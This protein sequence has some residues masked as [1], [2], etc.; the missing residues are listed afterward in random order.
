MAELKDGTLVQGVST[1]AYGEPDPFDIPKLYV[2]QGGQRQPIEHSLALVENGIDP[3]SVE[4]VDDA[5]LE[6]IPLAAKPRL[7][8]GQ[9]ITLDL[10]SFLGAGHYMKT[11]GV[12]RK[13]DWGAR[14]DATTRTWTVTLL[15]GFR[16]A[17][18]ILFSDAEGFPVGMTPT[19]SF[20]VD[21]KWIG[22]SDR[23]DFWSFDL[24]QDQAGRTTAITIFHFWNP[25]SLQ[26]TIARLVAAA[27]P[28]VEIIAEIKK[29]GGQGKSSG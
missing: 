12:L 6:Q 20:G 4:V 21:G 10:Q 24:T 15:G 2:I 27:K 23:T 22:R 1:G 18:D 9:Q 25:R 5:E 13:T 17:V 28:I 29:L 16:G 8:P 19:Q 3:A 7:G 26:D 11:Y 14:I